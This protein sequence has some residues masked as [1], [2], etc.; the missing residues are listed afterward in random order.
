MELKYPMVE[1]MRIASE[2]GDA[3]LVCDAWDYGP[4]LF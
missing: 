2:I 3:V 1:T 4:S